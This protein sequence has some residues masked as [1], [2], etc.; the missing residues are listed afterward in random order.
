MKRWLFFIVVCLSCGLQAQETDTLFILQT[1]D[2]HGNIYPYNYFTDQPDNNIGLAKIYS[3]VVEYRRNHKNIIL[4]DGGDLLQG[5]PLSDYFNNPDQPLVNPLILTM[6]YM[7]YDAFTVGNHDI[8][9]GPLAYLKAERESRYPWLSANSVMED[10]RTFFKP[11][12]IIK[13]DG[14][15]IGILG[16]TTPGIP[17][18]LDK[19]L[20]PGIEWKDMVKVARKY[21]AELIP[22]TDVLI[23]LFHAGFNADYSKEQSDAAGIPNENASKW[24]AE[25]VP[26]FDVVFAGHSHRAGPMKIGMENEM[27]FVEG[28][29]LLNAGSMAKNLGIIRL[30]LEKSAS[31]EWEIIRKSGWIESMENIEP[32]QSVMD[33]TK[34]Y[35]QQTLKY[36][37]TKIGTTTATLSAQNARFEDTSFMELINKVQMDYTGAD[38]S[39]AASFTTSFSLEKGD[40]LLKDVYGMYYYEN[41]LYMMEMTGQ[42]IKDYLEYSARYFIL[43][44]GKIE[45]DKNIAGYNYDI[46]EGIKYV[47]DVSKPIDQRITKMTNLDGSAFDLTKTYKVA[48]NSYRAE[49]GGGHLAAAKAQNNPVIFKSGKGMRHIIEEYIKK[50]GT[51]VP[52]VDNNW[53]LVK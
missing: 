14:I 3:R 6:N 9:Q 52:T 47:I 41:D 40:I 21:S 29:A 42:Q 37:R 33:L 2:V 50:M 35:H 27:D 17:L 12:T 34:Y 22:A 49:G 20:Y 48:L 24:V 31:G 5:T 28:P 26:G 11:F 16:L 38:I 15:K 51:I 44:D 30:I 4:V 10:G 23:G 36:I 46:A 45:T 13:R 18:W 1:T 32:S 7:G 25:Q 39:L 8:E 43:K 19:S 53:K